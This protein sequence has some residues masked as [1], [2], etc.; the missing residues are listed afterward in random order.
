METGY[1]KH[2]SR[3]LSSLKF[4]LDGGTY[5]DWD[6]LWSHDYPFSDANLK[7]LLLNLKPHQK[8]PVS[9]TMTFTSHSQWPSP[10]THNDL[11]LSLTMTFTSLQHIYSYAHFIFNIVQ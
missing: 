3:V 11:H 4:S 9:L 2:V 1:L 8:V 5:S 6:L 10:L 7:Q